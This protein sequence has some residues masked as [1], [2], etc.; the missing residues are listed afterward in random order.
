MQTKFAKKIL[1]IVFCLS[2]FSCSKAKDPYILSHLENIK[3]LEMQDHKFCTSLKLNFDQKNALHSELYWRCRL[4]FAKYR[5]STDTSPTPQQAKLNLEINDLITKISLKLSDSS[6]SVL[7]RENRKI[8][9]RQHKQ[10][11]VMGFELY[12]EDQAK[13]DDYFSCRKALIQDQQ[14]V[15]PYGNTDYLK[16]KDNAYNLGF[17]ID[18][19]T[20]H[21]IA[22]YNE[23]KKKYPTCIKY[24]LYS[25]NYKLC[26]AAQD[27][28]RKCFGEI[29]HKKFLKEGEEKISCQKQAYMRYTDEMLKEYEAR[30]KEIARMNAD[31]AFYNKQSFSAIGIDGTAFTVEKKKTPEDKMQELRVA[32]KKINSKDG[33]YDKYEL[34]KLRQKYIFSCQ[35]EAQQR[36]NKMEADLKLYC[37][38]LTKFEIIGEVVAE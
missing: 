13:I 27:K 14:L 16:Y 26:T 28:S 32:A 18:E 35:E 11:L 1:I 4:S 6:P 15:P 5:L 30:Q 20:D 29:D 36:V 22:N 24:N 25:E 12:T 37:E 31:S 3:L 38:G 19:R 8:D 23:E 21:K 17:A 2:M 33:L 9:N 10:C 7:L 34:T